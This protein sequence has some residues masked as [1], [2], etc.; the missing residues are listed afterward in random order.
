MSWAFLQD[1]GPIGMLLLGAAACAGVDLRGAGRDGSGAASRWVALAALVL[2]FAASIG[3][4]HSSFGPTPPDIE[5]GSLV[6]DR[7]ALFFYAATLAAAAAVLLCGADSESELDPHRGVFHLL[8]L[9]ST[10]GVLFTASSADVISMAAGLALA[11]LPVGLAQGLHKTDPDAVRSAARALSVSGFSLATLVGGLVLLAG[12]AGTT[13]LREIPVGLHQVDPLLVVAAIMLVLGAGLQLGV[14]PFL[15]WRAEEGP[16]PPAG[17]YLAATLLGSLAAA[18]ALLRLLPGALAAAPSTWTMAVA[19]L[20]GA[21]LVLAPLLAWRQR[22]LGRA[23]LYL[24]GAQLALGLATLPEISQSGTATILYLLLCTIPLGA[25]LLGL[26]GAVSAQGEGDAVSDL[27]G[28]WARSPALAGGLVL[29]LLGLAGLPPTAG[30]F[31]RLMTADS[32]LHAGLGWL[33]WLELL[34][35]VLCILVVFRWLLTI[36]DARADGPVLELPGR[37][38]L[39]GIGLCLAAVLSFGVLVGPL[40]AI[41]SR[42]ALPPLIGP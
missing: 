18:A 26:L 41:A 2:A 22:R 24:L 11:L 16:R 5:H 8:L 38:T 30:F 33:S 20:A 15:W 36:L 37:T 32:A 1:F 21:T 42:G 31:A 17:P 40:F 29:L 25:A 27:R 34:S 35:A 7:F 19:V 14:F 9:M 23:V 4:W 39:V 28:L 6:V 10:A 13:S 3:F 12:L